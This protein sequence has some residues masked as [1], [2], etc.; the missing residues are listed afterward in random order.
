M[1]DDDRYCS[2]CRAELPPNADSCP[3]CGV[4]AGDVFDGRIRR[5]KKPSSWGFW[6][7]VLLLAIGA[8]AYAVWMNVRP[9]RQAPREVAPETRVVKDRPGGARKAKGASVNEAEAIRLLR[10]HLVETKNINNDCLA[11][12]S[13]GNRKGGYVFNVYDRCGDV[14]LGRW[15]VDGKSGAVSAA[16]S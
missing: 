9:E 8:A 12:L 6:T 14:R 15:R 10:R 3:E 2:N 7:F 1:S 5:E 4:Y 13:A 16:S 11:L